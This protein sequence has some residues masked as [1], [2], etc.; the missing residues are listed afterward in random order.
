MKDSLLNTQVVREL[1]LNGGTAVGGYHT[2]DTIRRFKNMTGSSSNPI[3]LTAQNAWAA[4]DRISEAAEMANRIAIFKLLKDRG[5]TL[6]KAGFEAK[7]ILDFGLTGRS[8]VVKFLAT[9]VPFMNARAQGSYRLARGAV[10]KGNRLNFLL[11]G[12]LL[13][14]AAVALRIENEDDE[15]YIALP[16]AAKDLYIHFWVDRY[17]DK[18][19]LESVGITNPHFTMPKPFEL[20]FLAMT[21]PE[22]AAAIA[23]AEDKDSAISK[24]FTS[25]AWGAR[26]IFKL[27]PLELLGPVAKGFF[28]DLFN[29]NWHYDKQIVPEHFMKFVGQPHEGEN[30]RDP[31]A[32]EAMKELAKSLGMAPQR[33]QNYMDS[34]FPKVGNLTMTVL[35]GYYRDSIGLPVI[36]REWKRTA[37]GQITTGW[38]NPPDYPESTMHQK[39]LQAADRAMS[40]LFNV[41]KIQAKNNR[42]NPGPRTRELL[43]EHRGALVGM[44]VARNALKKISN[45]YKIM[46]EINNSNSIEANEKIQYKR[47]YDRMRGETARLA[48]QN[49]KTLKRKNQAS[50]K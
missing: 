35:D 24:A 28:E 18:D 21:L 15:R 10:Q 29:K 43:E 6:Y 4:L 38:A 47:L 23:I 50:T 49:I 5:E 37:M 25:A 44:D 46:E 13:A 45:T 7:D 14:T 9:T 34:W 2:N 31:Y 39:D 41:I 16:Q 19:I 42:I 17:I 20:G 40:A 48:L 26:E 3:I 22:R 8:P 36:P 11:W 30:V 1:Q 27:N 32:S 12:G 33:V